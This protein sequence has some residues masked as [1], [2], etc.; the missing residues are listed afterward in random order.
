MIIRDLGPIGAVGG[1]NLN[2]SGLWLFTVYLQGAP[3]N[4]TGY[5]TPTLALKV[6]R[7][8]TDAAVVVIGT[9]AI[10]TA[11]TG[12]MSYTPGTADPIHGV[13]GV[14]EAKLWVTV[15]SKPRPSDL[16]RFAIAEGPASA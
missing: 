2:T 10:V 7:I 6:R 11:A 13:S 8:P 4:L 3:W 14:Y 16:F 1:L 5:T 9:V 15:S 12:A